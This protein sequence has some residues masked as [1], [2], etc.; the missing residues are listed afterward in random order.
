[1]DMHIDRM[2]FPIVY[3]RSHYTVMANELIKGKQEMT[4]QEARILRLVITQVA[5]ED[6]DLKTY[7]CNIKDLAS[8]LGIPDANLYR[9]IRDIC[10]N[11]LKRIVSI[12]TGNPREPWHAFQWIQLAQYD[13]RGTIT[14]MLSE[15]IKP[16]V[17][18]LD[19]Y[20]TR[21]KLENILHMNSFYAI[22]LYELIKCDDYR[23]DTDDRE[24]TIDFLRKFF[25]CE[26][27]Y[28]LFA[29][30]KRR[31]LEVAVREINAKSDL[32]IR[33]IKYLKTGHKVTS[34]VFVIDTD[35]VLQEEEPQIPGQL[36][37]GDL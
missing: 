36:R 12:S 2:L 6:K 1:M 4:L 15:Q 32:T 3:D 28:Q 22:R 20:F 30:F 8:F 23:A 26:K 35:A 33:R 19:K 11:L 31:V 25:D 10:T 17:L 13:G 16:F 9:D 7:I 37:L 5:K 14:L 27:K 29:D 21:Y 34:V 18:E 24:Y